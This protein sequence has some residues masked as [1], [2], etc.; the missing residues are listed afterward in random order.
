MSV[1]FD[2][3]ILID[4]LMG[5]VP[6]VEQLNLYSA[7]AISVVNWMEVMSGAGQGDEANICR[8]FLAQFRCLDV[9]GRVAE[10]AADLRKTLKLK[11]P[12][13]VILATAR[14][15]QAVLITRDTAFPADMP[16]IRIPYRL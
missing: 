16:G 11:L 5:H 10:E 15:H 1:L 13:A 12:D 9:D 7:S 2:T 6:A 14:T 4:C 3:N 8:R